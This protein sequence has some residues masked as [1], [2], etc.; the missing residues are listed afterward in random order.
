MEFFCEL[1]VHMFPRSST[2]RIVRVQLISRVFFNLLLK[3]RVT[4]CSS[5]PG[6]V[7]MYACCLSTIISS[8]PFTPWS[9]PYIA[10]FSIL[11]R[12]YVPH[13]SLLPPFPHQ[14]HVRL[15]KRATYS[16]W[17]LSFW[18]WFGFSCYHLL[19]IS[20]YSSLADCFKF[21][22]FVDKSLY[23]LEENMLLV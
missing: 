13:F 5:L 11:S 2:S 7:S 9:W 18:L 16:S 10:C 17:K 22:W 20:P 15:G 8:A 23:S 4:I 14:K 3:I 19:S 21:L 1:P 6:T 12:M